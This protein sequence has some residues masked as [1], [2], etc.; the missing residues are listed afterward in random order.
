MLPLR[1]DDGGGGASSTTT[2][3]FGRQVTEQRSPQGLLQQRTRRSGTNVLTMSMTYLAG[4]V[5]PDQEAEEYPAT[6]TDEAGAR[7]SLATRRSDSSTNAG[8]RE[9][10]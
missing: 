10:L 6:G 3:P 7:G 5:S 2:D 8:V 4:L 1:R 9:D